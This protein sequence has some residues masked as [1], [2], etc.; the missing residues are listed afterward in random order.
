LEEETFLIDGKLNYGKQG[1]QI[2]KEIV[3]LVEQGESSVAD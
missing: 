2:K 1:K 3:F